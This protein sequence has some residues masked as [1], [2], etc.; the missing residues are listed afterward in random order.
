MNLDDLVAT[1]AATLRQRLGTR[2][3]RIAVLLGSGWGPLADEVQGICAEAGVAISEL[4]THLQGQLVAVNPA[5]DA[6]FDAFAPEAVRGNPAARQAWAVDQVT[7]AATAARRLGLSGTV[8]FTGSL[9]FPY[10]Y[11]W[12]QRPAGLGR[13]LWPARSVVGRSARRGLQPDGARPLSR[14]PRD[15]AP[16]R[17]AL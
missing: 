16:G 13:A 14:Q 12:P 3:P 15:T 9:A 10:L 11:P 8:S 1:S 4:S 7:K 5:Y 17:S 6:A 2:Q